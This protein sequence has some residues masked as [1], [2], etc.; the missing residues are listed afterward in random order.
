M[1]SYLA[2]SNIASH[3]ILFKFNQIYIFNF[4]SYYINEKILIDTHLKFMQKN[5]VKDTKQQS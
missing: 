5:Y 1:R 3:K 2:Y 4:S